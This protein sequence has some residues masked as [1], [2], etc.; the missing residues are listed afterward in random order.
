M[1]QTSFLLYL[2]SKSNSIIK[3]QS[4]IKKYVEDAC[5]MNTASNRRKLIAL[6]VQFVLEHCSKHCSVKNTLYNI[7]CICQDLL[8]NYIFLHTRTTSRTPFSQIFFCR[9]KNVLGSVLTRLYI[10][11]L[12][13]CCYIELFSFLLLNSMKGQ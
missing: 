6:I 10:L 9:I 7:Q 12:F 3:I 5:R 11:L 2:H 8:Q 1:Y 13:F 4:I